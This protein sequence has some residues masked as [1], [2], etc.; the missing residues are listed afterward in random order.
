MNSPI[1]FIVSPQLH[2]IQLQRSCVEQILKNNIPSSTWQNF[3]N[4][5]E[6]V[7]GK[8]NENGIDVVEEM[9]FDLYEL[10][11][12]AFIQRSAEEYL[13]QVFKLFVRNQKYS[14]YVA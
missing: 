13:A 1:Y 3:S 7:F 10:Q 14:Q 2:T 6:Y 9:D 11:D 12:T 5:C 8:P 4:Y